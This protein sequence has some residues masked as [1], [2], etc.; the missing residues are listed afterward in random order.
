[1]AKRPTVPLLG[2][3]R[4]G[5]WPLSPCRAALPGPP[6][7]GHGPDA[8]PVHRGLPQGDTRPPDRADPRVWRLSS[9]LCGG[10]RVE[11]I[12]LIN[13]HVPP[14]PPGRRTSLSVGHSLGLAAL[15]RAAWPKSK[16]AFTAWSQGTVLARLVPALPDELRSQRFWDQMNLFESEHFAPIQRELLC[17]MHERFPLGAQ[18][19]VDDTTNSYPFLH[20]CNSRPS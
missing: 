15:N 14:A 13:A 9:L 4:W 18:F 5:Q 3:L 16:R 19:L 8:C 7:P 1:M 11:L 10:P 6:G 2:P 20:P 17:R 12:E